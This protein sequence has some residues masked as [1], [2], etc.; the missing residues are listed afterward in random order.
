MAEKL[1][2]FP[3]KK[4]DSLY[5]WQTWTDGSIWK[6]TRGTD[7]ECNSAAMRSRFYIHAKRNAMVVKVHA[8]DDDT[9]VFQFRKKAEA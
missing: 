5:P 7:F 1:E 9:L 3:C 2:S 6:I 8:V 4:N